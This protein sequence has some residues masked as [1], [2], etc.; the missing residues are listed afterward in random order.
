MTGEQLLTTR[1]SSPAP[2]RSGPA[3]TCMTYLSPGFMPELGQQGTG[4]RGGRVGSRV[5]VRA[6]EAPDAA[7][8][9]Q[10][11]RAR[12]P[13]LGARH[14]PGSR[15]AVDLDVWLGRRRRA[16]RNGSRASRRPAVEARSSPEPTMSTTEV[17][18]LLKQIGWPIKVTGTRTPDDR[19]GDQ[20]LPA[21][22]PRRPARD[23]ASR[24]WAR[25]S[26][27]GGS[28]ALRALRTVA[29]ARRTSCSGSLPPPSPA[30]SARTGNWCSAWRSSGITSV[31]RSGSCRVSA[32]STSARR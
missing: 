32:T 27:D 1:R 9:L 28:A 6:R 15:V 20:G 31:T 22:L 16:C 4:A 7:G 11:A 17:Q 25:R 14:V 5:L 23:G 13:V 24:G 19:A 12:T 8:L 30:G 26:E 2:W 10:D 29:A 18:T 3:A 21:R